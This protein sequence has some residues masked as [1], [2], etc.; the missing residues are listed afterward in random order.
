MGGRVGADLGPGDR[1]EVPGG[2][3]RFVIG[4]VLREHFNRVD[5]GVGVDDPVVLAAEQRQVLYRVDVVRQRGLAGPRTLSADANDM[6]ALRES[7]WL[8]PG[9][10]L[11]RDRVRTA[12]EGALITGKSEQAVGDRIRDAL[13]PTRCHGS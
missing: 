3:T 8:L 10:N 5:T 7:H 11:I 9:R 6:G 12:G 13:A 2:H 4:L 1:A